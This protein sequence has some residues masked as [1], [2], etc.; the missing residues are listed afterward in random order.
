MLTKQNLTKG[1]ELETVGRAFLHAVH[2]VAEGE[3]YLQDLLEL[4]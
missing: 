3:D 1:G 2:V 4:L